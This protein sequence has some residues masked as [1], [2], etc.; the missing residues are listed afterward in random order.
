[1]MNTMIPLTIAN[2]LDQSAKQRVE[3]KPNQT[4]KNVVQQHDLAPKGNYDIYDREGKVISNEPAQNHRE[5]TVYVGVSKIAGG[6]IHP[7]L[8][9]DDDDDWD[10]D[11]PNV[12]PGEVT[13]K[14][15]NGERHSAQPKKSETL[16]DT[17]ER[18]VGGPRDGTTVEIIDSN[19]EDVSSRRSSDMIG[20]AFSVGLKKIIGGGFPR[21]RIHE[22]QIEYPSI[23]AVGK[24]SSATEIQMFVVR[25]PSSGKTSSGFWEIAIYCPNASSQLM[26]AYVLNHSE[27]SS[28]PSVSLFPRPPSASYASGAG[29]GFVPGTKRTGHW[30]CHGH[31][32]PHLNALGSDPIKRIGAYINHIQN[33]LNQ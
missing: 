11:E 29:D 18:V 32:L 26:H 14:L 15:T 30:I 8:D 28:S 16:F 19:Y 23:R 4:L 5:A 17:F 7:G 3:A 20:R 25:F 2:T 12:K 33:L 6:A 10:I 13:F 27:I 1:M 22:L 21:N 31:I 9:F 24:H